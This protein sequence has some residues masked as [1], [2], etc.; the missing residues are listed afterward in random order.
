MHIRTLAFCLL[1]VLL[2][3]ASYAVESYPV[4]GKVVDVDGNPVA[5]IDVYA[6]GV[7]IDESKD[8]KVHATVK[9]NQDGSFIFESPRLGMPNQPNSFTHV[10]CVASEPGKLLGWSEIYLRPF[11][12]N[13]KKYYPILPSK[14]VVSTPHDVEGQV[15]DTKGAPIPDAIVSH[16]LFKLKNEGKETGRIYTRP[17]YLTAAV[18]LIPAVTDASGK[19]RLSNVPEH[20]LIQPDAAKKDW[21]MAPRKYNAP[22]DLNITMVPGGSLSGKLLKEGGEPISDALVTVSYY[23]DSEQRGWGKA[24]TSDDGSFHID[25]LAPGLYQLLVYYVKPDNMTLRRESISVK[26]HKDTSL[27]NLIYPKTVLVSGRVIDSDTGKPINGAE[28]AVYSQDFYGPSAM[29]DKSGRYSI[30][31]F[32]GSARIKYRGG[33]PL[34]V[35]DDRAQ[36]PVVK[37]PKSGLKNYIIKV[38]GSELASGKVVDEKGNPVKAAS[39]TV[40]PLNFGYNRSAITDAKGRFK[41]GLPSEQSGG[42]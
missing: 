17:E 4:K 29:S 5:G 14:I 19:Y 9:T 22:P 34:Y 7:K 30:K 11:Q 33:N 12:N 25:G 26:A 28:V 24:W 32:P 42:G 39:V 37:I 36:P 15:T 40:G 8:F 6:L 10:I 18:K 35:P 1:V 27:G 2:P 3:I 38:S 21:A 41:I 13:L 23:S 31:T 16:G 20:R